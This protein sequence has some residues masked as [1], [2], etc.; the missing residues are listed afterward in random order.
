MAPDLW[1]QFCWEDKDHIIGGNFVCKG[2][3][4]KLSLH[5]TDSEI[6]QSVFLAAKVA[7]E[8]EIREAFKFQGRPVMRPHFDVYKLMELC[9][10][11][12]D[13]KRSEVNDV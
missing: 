8:H 6:V 9:D 4:W 1:F 11:N 12:A 3:K 10:E 13:S 7:M 2:R 5:M